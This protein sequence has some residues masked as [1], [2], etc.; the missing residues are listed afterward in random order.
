MNIVRIPTPAEGNPLFPLPADYYELA[1]DGQ[2]KAR[3]N[4]CRQWLLPGT[5]DQKAEARVCSLNFFDKYY[6]WPDTE[7]SY[8]PLF[9]DEA[10]LPSPQM[11]WDMVRSWAVYRMNLDIWPRGGG[12]SSVMRKDIALCSIS[13]PAYSTVYATSTH[14]NAKMTG[15]ILKDLCYEN[16]R[17]SDDWAPEYGGRLKPVRGEAPT[18]IEFFYLNND[19]WVRCIS[20][21]SRVRGLRPRRFRLDDPEYDEKASTSLSIL[22]AYM[23]RLLFKLALP[24]V[25]RGGCGVDWTATFVSKRHYAFHAMQ[26]VQTPEGLAAKDPRFNFWHR[27]VIHAA[28]NDPAG[29]LVSCWPQMWPTTRAV[30]AAD[31]ALA[32][33]ISLE[34]IRDTI[35]ISN[36]N[37][38]YMANP[39]EGDSRYFGDLIKEKHRYWFED[40]DGLL[41][42]KPRLS[43]ARIHWYHKDKLQSQ[44]L[45]TFL[46]ERRLFITADTSYTANSDS[47]YKVACCM[48][49]DY[50]T[51]E[52]FVLDLWSG[53]CH[54]KI[55][56]DK[57][58]H[59][60]D[61][62]RVPTVH[63]ELVRESIS[64]YESLLDACRTRATTEMGLT[65][66]PS[67][68]KDNK[69]GN[70]N[71]EA[72]I[73]ALLFRF[74][75]GLIKLP[76]GAGG[77]WWV[78]LESQIDEY[79][80]E[81][82]GGGVPHDDEI[83]CCSMSR[84]IIRGRL[85]TAPL[86][87]EEP[88]PTFVER[89]LAGETH[90]HG[91]PIGMGVDWSTVLPDVVDRLMQLR[92][93][94]PGDPGS[95]PGTR[96]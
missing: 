43:S 45:S 40:V 9:Y 37:S 46:A 13:R 20:A 34:E 28:Y 57:I 65:F 89:L 30:K 21:E 23:N 83:D 67:I 63:P 92:S 90:L 31:P 68:L 38:E 7:A 95:R 59:M 14:D 44:T 32:N 94:K 76:L 69:P 52:L 35:G 85:A 33:R 39:G 62:W 86:P 71:K 91:A 12:K 11:H 17:I 48:A 74:E 18:G 70:D 60:A 49:I 1:D 4:A 50:K 79:N 87:E 26:T 8:D 29:N 61:R 27:H 42:D 81:V 47:D 78:R 54:E 22:R 88:T 77:P 36:F 56:V 53:Q 84:K 5:D 3:V 75:H 96:A 41:A 25:M 80:P 10:P 72:K 24:M 51:N 82:E 64:L 55:L 6:L 66:T 16:P 58:L 93:D 15:Q 2:R 73:A 19:S